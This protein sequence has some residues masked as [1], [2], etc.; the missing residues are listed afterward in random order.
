MRMGEAFRMAGIDEHAIAENYV[1][2]ADVLKGGD[3]GRQAGQKLLLEVLKE[4]TRV[5]EPPQRAG[6]ASVAD[7]PPVQITLVHNVARPVRPAPAPLPSAAS[8]DGGGGAVTPDTDAS[9]FESPE[10][11]EA[12]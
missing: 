6:V 9:A 1:N 12:S 2:V 5:L 7:V 11:P 10:T 4:W 8:R 3:S